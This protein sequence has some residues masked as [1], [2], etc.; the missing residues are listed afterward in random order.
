MTDPEPIPND[1]PLLAMKNVII[2]PHVASASVNAARR[3]RI[4][5]ANTAACAV[6]G[7]KVPNVVNGVV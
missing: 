5:V 1:S 7:E 4:S 2:T 6:R 3:L